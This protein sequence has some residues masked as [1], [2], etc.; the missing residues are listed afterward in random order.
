MAAMHL[1]GCLSQ[2]S[3]LGQTP[4]S[5]PISRSCQP[6]SCS[7]HPQRQSQRESRTTCATCS[8]TKQ[9]E[10]TPPAWLP[11]PAQPCRHASSQTLRAAADA[12][13]LDDSSAPEIAQEKLRIKLKAYDHRLLQQAVDL[14]LEAARSTGAK[15]GGAASLPTK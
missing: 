14:V 4:R 7:G 15:V 13:L 9:T 8:V 12:S 5:C 6:A 11:G 1:P 2:R 3:A 10:L